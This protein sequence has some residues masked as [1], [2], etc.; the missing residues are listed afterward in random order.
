MTNSVRKILV[1]EDEVEIRE[2]LVSLL[3]EK[4]PEVIAAENGAA[5]LEWLKKE[6]FSLIV[7]DINMPVMNGLT[8]YSE[9]KAMG[10]QTPFVFVTAFGDQDNMLSALRLGAFDFIKK[11]FDD[12]DVNQVVDR[13]MEVGF[14]RN[15]IL[16]SFKDAQPEI[17]NAMNKNEKFIRL[18]QLSNYKKRA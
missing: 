15:Q 10:V 18:L 6:T 5:A 13:A 2:I 9:A 8:F 4:T 11:P 12:E 7:S 3:K 16:E 17:Q 14:R 1:V